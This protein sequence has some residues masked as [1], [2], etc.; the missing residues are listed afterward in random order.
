MQPSSPPLPRVL[1]C[2]FA[3]VI[4]F[5]LG[6]HP[7]RAATPLGGL[8]VA[9]S[10]DGTQLVAAGDSRAFYDIEPATLKVKRR[11][12]FGRAVVSMGFS[13]SGKQLVVES[14]NAISL[15]DPS[16]FKVAR[17]IEGAD[18]L[19][20]APSVGLA[21]Y[22]SRKRPASVR[23]LNLASGKEI[24]SIEYD[25][26]AGL[27]AMGLSPDGKR[28]LIFGSG[29]RDE[30]EKEIPRKDRP[31][32]LKGA[33]R[34]EYHHK[35]DGRMAP[36]RIVDVTTGKNIARGKSWV[37]P[38]GGTRVTWSGQEAFVSTYGNDN[39]RVAKDGTIHYFAMHNS[40]NYGMGSSI[41]GNAILSGGLR[42]GSR[43]A[44]PSLKATTF[45]LKAVP[46]FPEYWRSF[47]LSASGTGFGG[48]SAF[49]V[50]RI[51]AKGTIEQVAFIH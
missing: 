47:S 2:G 51:D 3:I 25:V 38:G 36:F 20:V 46:G 39:A 15:V 18:F 12:P 9:I 19:S 23:I 14:T 11:A 17:T 31:K 49:R 32:D 16:T 50:A 33:A 5:G 34:T 40:Y 26:S 22:R 29:R 27:S 42:K 24:A 37:C 28:L 45:E 4:L 8:A 21:A 13:G 6:A 43:T 1:A 35:H 30:A 10:P 41:T 48:T 44:L 7:G